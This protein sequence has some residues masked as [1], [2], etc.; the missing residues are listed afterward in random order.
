MYLKWVMNMHILLCTHFLEDV[1][2][3]IIYH[4]GLSIPMKYGYSSL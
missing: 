1:T 3:E 2:H 4:R